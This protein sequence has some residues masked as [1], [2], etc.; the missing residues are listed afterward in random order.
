MAG[1]RTFAG[2]IVVATDGSLVL[3]LRDDKP[4][5]ADPNKL[6]IFAG[7]MLPG[8][9][10]REAALREL[11][12][13][14]SLTVREDELEFFVAYQ[15]D[16]ARHGGTG[17]TTIFVLKGVDVTDLQVYEG[18]GYRIVHG[19]DELSEANCALISYDILIEYFKSA[20]QPT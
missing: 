1:L 2:V 16:P 15:K 5:I 19:P 11:Q 9:T 6:S 14:T 4:T 12:E 17:T 20:D 7:L 13:E 10:P 3:Q 8:E 18:Q